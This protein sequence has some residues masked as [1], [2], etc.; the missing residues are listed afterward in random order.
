M[1]FAPGTQASGERVGAQVTERVYLT[2]SVYRLTFES[3]E[4][5]LLGCRSS[6]RYPGTGPMSRICVVW[7]ARA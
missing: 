6:N 7:T 4:F 1:W 3:A 5:L 2:C